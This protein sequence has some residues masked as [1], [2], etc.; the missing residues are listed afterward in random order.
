MQLS[1]LCSSDNATTMGTNYLKTCDSQ[2]NALAVIMKEAKEHGSQ[3]IS[4]T[5][6]PCDADGSFISKQCES[7]QCYCKT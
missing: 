1:L 4:L 5:A 7:S 3:P 6:P 2:S